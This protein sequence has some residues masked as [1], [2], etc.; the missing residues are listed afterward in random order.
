MTESEKN[1]LKAVIYWIEQKIKKGEITIEEWRKELKQ[2]T[3][4][5][6]I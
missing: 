3:N 5:I 6:L 1:N 4:I 2:I